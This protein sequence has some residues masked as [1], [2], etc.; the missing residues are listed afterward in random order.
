MDGSQHGNVNKRLWLIGILLLAV[1]CVWLEMRTPDP[2]GRETATGHSNRRKLPGA[3]DSP[4]DAARLRTK[5]SSR[6]NTNQSFTHPP[7]RLKEFMLPAMKIEGLT[8]NDSLRKLMASYDDACRKS[9]ET[10]LPLTFAIP[11]GAARKLTLNLP[12]A[13][14]NSSV[15]LLATLSGMK[16]IRQ[17]REYQFELLPNERKQVK[18]DLELPSNFN[19]TLSD[20][21]G[22]TTPITAFA[23]D[24]PDIEMPVRDLLTTLGLELDPST[25]MSVGASG[26][27][28]FE[29]TSAADAAAVVALAKTINESP[30]TQ[31]KFTTKLVELS[32]DLDYLLPDLNLSDVADLTDGQ[33][34]L[35][36]RNLAQK[37]G[38]DLMTMP[39]FTARNGQEGKIEILRELISPADDTGEAFEKHNVGVVMK[40]KGSRLGFGQEVDFNFTNTTGE[41]D[42]TS[43][44]ALISKMV[45]ANSGFSQDGGIRFI[46]Q[47]R[48][49]G[50][51]ILL[52]VTS[53]VIDATGRPIRNPQSN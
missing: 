47:T 21:S 50:R 7:E 20:M 36:M 18:L 22:L 37:K 51:Q 11:P 52:L 6:E 12:P 45:I 48:S 30:P 26:K 16:V 19:R 10:P 24:S 31:L 28:I 41:L 29:T 8:L 44:K 34:Q 23:S 15:R 1:L 25:R 40:S 14:F 33:A 43:G 35:L 53:E 17:G 32:H 49:D 38:T 46:K 3:E 9:G 5:A 13:S 4:D 39:T 42:A 2:Q 27:L